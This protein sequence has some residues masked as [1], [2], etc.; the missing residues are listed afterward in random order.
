MPPNII[1]KLAAR[2]RFSHFLPFRMIF[3]V[4]PA[5]VCVC[6]WVS[7]RAKD[8]RVSGIFIVQIFPVS[9]RQFMCK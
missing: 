1:V 2:L 5:C 4:P 7:E 3:R 9:L 6:V 8:L